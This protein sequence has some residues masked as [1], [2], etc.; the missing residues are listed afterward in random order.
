MPEPST[1]RYKELLYQIGII[2]NFLK[3]NLSK[4]PLI[5]SRE[6]AI[7]EF[8]GPNGQ[9]IKEAADAYF[10]CIKGIFPDDT[11]IDKELADEYTKSMES[12][13]MR[14]FIFSSYY[15]YSEAEVDREIDKCLDEMEK[16]D[17]KEYTLEERQKDKEELEEER[18]LRK[19]YLKLN[20][21]I[22]EKLAEVFKHD[23]I[24]ELSQEDMRVIDK[25]LMHIAS[26]SK[27]MDY[28]TDFVELEKRM[29]EANKPI[30]PDVRKRFVQTFLEEKS[31][32]ENTGTEPPEAI[33]AI[34]LQ[35]ENYYID[36][37]CERL[38]E[39]DKK[40]S[41]AEDKTVAIDEL[42]EDDTLNYIIQMKNKNRL[43]GQDELTE[44]C[45]KLDTRIQ[46]IVKKYFTEQDVEEAK[47]TMDNI[48]GPERHSNKNIRI[49]DIWNPSDLKQ[50]EEAYKIVYLS[51]LLSNNQANKESTPSLDSIFIVCQILYHN[52][53]NQEANINADILLKR[54]LQKIVE[55]ELQTQ[56]DQANEQGAK[57]DNPIVV[58]EN[59]NVKSDETF[60]SLNP[61]KQVFEFSTE[62]AW[63]L[64]DRPERFIKVIF[65]EIDH[66]IK[67]EKQKN[68]ICSNYLDYLVMKSQIITN[69]EP[70]WKKYSYDTIFSEV[71]ADCAGNM[72]M[73]RS[74]GQ[75][76]GSNS[77]IDSAAREI[78]KLFELTDRNYMIS[79]M[80][81]MR[82]VKI[83]DDIVARK[84][85]NK[86]GKNPEN[87][88]L[89]ILDFEYNKD[90]TPKTYEQILEDQQREIDGESYNPEIGPNN[91]IDRTK[92]RMQIMMD[93][94][95]A[96][97]EYESR[98]DEKSLKLFKRF[99]SKN[100]DVL[101][102]DPI[103]DYFNKSNE[104]KES[105]IR[106]MNYHR[107]ET[108]YQGTETA[109]CD[110]LFAD[111]LSR[112]M[113]K[114]LFRYRV[115]NNIFDSAISV[116]IG[117]NSKEP[118]EQPEGQNKPGGPDGQEQPF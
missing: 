109:L 114:M 14:S 46:T 118:E 116:W 52:N 93:R 8:L 85:E 62:A 10:A 111:K 69:A 117:E 11:L 40:M 24:D 71:M 86:W 6:V 83:M 51:E 16:V 72:G 29:K 82:T 89:E 95:L 65:H 50:L 60:G 2:E 36:Y 70:A 96:S 100:Y 87:L 18:I 30:S 44:K 59:F 107:D 57:I 37:A 106:T 98:E 7:D 55:K 53:L 43:G 67:I 78:F 15:L 102:G 42:W 5:K 97:K 84:E 108:L 38:D 35:A 13:I 49:S 26:Y 1:Q 56:I 99:I 104:I 63:I 25:Q 61:T 110:A 23:N 80:G 19:K 20:D 31:K 88:A 112:V 39:F 58:G 22:I 12:L 73:I 9:N 66:F 113:S 115:R 64:H 68:H 105:T 28:F 76:L 33:K 91:I 75:L 41:E 47:A 27:A 101:K 81:R 74:V 48:L 4:N 92:F 103:F 17:A 79:H 45:N 90:G 34:L 3:H 32:Y 21:Y 77:A 94:V 54:V